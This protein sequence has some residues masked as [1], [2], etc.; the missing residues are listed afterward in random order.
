M[1][2]QPPTDAEIERRFHFQRP[3][4]QDRIDRHD[5]VSHLTC[6]L[7]KQIR[8]ICPPGRNLALALTA[9]EDVRMRANAALATESED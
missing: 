3:P 7:A 5:K 1:N 9:L 8:D 6:E 4:N 2:L